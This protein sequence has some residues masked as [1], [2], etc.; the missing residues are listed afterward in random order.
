MSSRYFLNHQKNSLLYKYYLLGDLSWWD[1]AKG[2]M[3]TEK[4]KNIIA[5]FLDCLEKEKFLITKIE[6]KLKTRWTFSHLPP[7]EKAI[8]IYASHEI[9]FNK[10]VFIPSLIDQTIDFSKKYLEPNKYRYI[11]KALDLIYKTKI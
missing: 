9:F 7:L 3:L 1:Q 5:W 11:N 4:Q 10:N 6:S 2:Q 8:L